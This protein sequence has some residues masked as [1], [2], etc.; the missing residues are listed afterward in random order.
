ML[1]GFSIVTAI[2][3]LRPAN[4]LVP[5]RTDVDAAIDSARVAGKPA[6]L[7]FTAT[8]CG[9]CQQMKQD[10]WS[11]AAVEARLR[12]YVPVKIDIDQNGE[13]ARRYN[14]EA[15]PMFV[16]VDKDGQT[17]KRTTGYMTPV[18]FIAWVDG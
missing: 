4:D 9:P 12:D 16:L 13:L 15:V 3:K 8:W 7:Y 1:A 10:T 14:T 2:S 6:L 17:I 11:D 18:Q 5:W